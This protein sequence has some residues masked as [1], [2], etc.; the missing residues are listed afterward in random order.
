MA[1]LRRVAG[2]L[3][4]IENMN[5]ILDCFQRKGS[6]AAGAAPVMMCFGCWMM[7]LICD[8]SNQAKWSGRCAGEK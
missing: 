8:E 1:R 7:A 5:V 4:N 2:G 6:G 3:D